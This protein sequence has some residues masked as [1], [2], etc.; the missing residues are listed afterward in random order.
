LTKII[1]GRHSPDDGLAETETDIRRMMAL[2]RLSFPPSMDFGNASSSTID[3]GI[4]GFTANIYFYD[5]DTPLKYFLV[6]RPNLVA[7][8]RVVHAAIDG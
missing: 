1:S 8:C 2:A 7:H 6:S 3:A 4:Y 5:I